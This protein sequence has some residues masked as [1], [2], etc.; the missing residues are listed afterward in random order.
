[1]YLTVR[2]DKENQRFYATIDGI[3]NEVRY[4][5]INPKLF[6]FNYLNIDQQLKDKGIEEELLYNAFVFAQ[7]EGIKVIP[8]CEIV[9]SYLSKHKEFTCVTVLE[10]PA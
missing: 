4:R 8:G 1:M 9:S 6:E 5:I 10:Q 7:K 3:D 2:L